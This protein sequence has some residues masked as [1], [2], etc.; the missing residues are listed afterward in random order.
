VTVLTATTPP[1]KI[2][3]PNPVRLTFRA[4]PIFILPYRSMMP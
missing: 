4:I 3:P 1:T 2:S